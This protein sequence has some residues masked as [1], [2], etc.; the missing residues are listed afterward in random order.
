MERMHLSWSGGDTGS[1]SVS[2]TCGTVAIIFIIYI[3]TLSVIESIED[4]LSHPNHG[5]VPPAY[6]IFYFL[7]MM[8]RLAFLIYMVM[9]IAKTRRYI[10]EKHSIREKYCHGMEDCCCAYWC[11]CLTI[12][13]MARHT[14][15]YDTYNARCCTSTGLPPNAPAIV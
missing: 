15:D 6:Y 10:R 4:G 3:F 14:A 8:L 12:A 11:P 7:H 13:Q 1:T 2:G 9:A 5:N